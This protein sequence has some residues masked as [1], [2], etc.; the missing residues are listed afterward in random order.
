ME[1]DSDEDAEE[2]NSPGNG[3]YLDFLRRRVLQHMADRAHCVDARTLGD[4]D[5][6]NLPAALR[7]SFDS[8]RTEH[9]DVEE[10][11]AAAYKVAWQGP[12]ARD[13]LPSWEAFFGGAADLLYYAPH[14]KADYTPFLLE[15]VG[16]PQKLRTFFRHLYF[17]TVPDALSSIRIDSETRPS[18]HIRS[19]VM[20]T[21]DTAFRRPAGYCA[22]GRR[23]VPVRRAPLDRYLKAP[24]FDTP[25]TWVAGIAERL[26]RA[27][28]D[29]LVEA[30]RNWYLEAV[31]EMLADPKTA[32]IEGDNFAAW[33]RACHREVYDDIDTYDPLKLK[34]LRSAKGKSGRRHNI[35]EIR[36][37]GADEAFV[38]FAKGEPAKGSR[39]Q[40]LS[41][42][43]VDSF[44]LRSV[45]LAM[46][47]KAAEVA[48]RAPEGE[49]LV[50]VQYAGLDHTR[51]AVKFWRSQGFKATGLPNC[52]RLGKDIWEDDERRAL[53]LPSYLKDLSTLFPVPDT[54]RD[55]E[56]GRPQ[57][58]RTI[59]RK[60]MS[61]KSRNQKA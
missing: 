52:G 41:K 36:I 8:F 11:E 47:L 59:Q 57:K 4:A 26:R 3:S 33:L 60:L 16:K 53:T 27:G 12:V 20:E 51:M 19:L 10:S 55:V 22:S 43:I 39:Q 34:R 28:A 30:A 44:Q 48:L 46:V 42:I 54:L 35:E 24:G 32:D 56:K 40:V 37:P 61:A 18:T 7:G 25:R 23:T 45:D 49:R 5:D 50:I 14:V 58:I 17:G 31:D 2:A 38:E 6:E 13:H 9:T 29:S 21:A 1:P 15:C